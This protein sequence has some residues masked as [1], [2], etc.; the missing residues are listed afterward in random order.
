[1]GAVVPLETVEAARR[2]LA[3]AGRTLVLTNGYFDLLHAGHAR[4]LQQ[5][6]A[7]GDALVVGVNADATARQ[8]KDP[9]RPIVLQGDR[10]ELVA[11]LAAV[12]YVVIFEEP[13]AEALVAR[14]RPDVYVKGG[15]YTL[16]D[17]P[18]AAV[19]RSYG[20]RV[21]LL[22]YAEG[23]STTAIIETVVARYCPA[24]G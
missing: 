8:A 23:R 21:V 18:E 3:A 11:A 22:P 1:M 2:E 20:G 16:D 7:L 13:T 17:L 15:D 6:K 14:L 10:A 24:P 12:D 9:R 19:A 5:A 4:Y